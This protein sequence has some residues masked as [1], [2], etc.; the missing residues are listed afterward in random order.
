MEL[1]EVFKVLSSL[2]SRSLDTP[3]PHGGSSGSLQ[4]LH[5]GQGST[6]LA[7]QIVDIPVP[8]GGRQDP[9][10]PSAASSSG[11]PDPANQGVFRTFP[12]G[13]KSAKMGPHS[14]S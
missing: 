5:P 2:L 7:A 12:R 3:V 11:L 4:G 9:D 1:L 10:L 13:K 8:H 6:A 14:G